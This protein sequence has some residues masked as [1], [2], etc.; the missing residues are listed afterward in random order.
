MPIY[1]GHLPVDA[2]LGKVKVVCMPTSTQT[3]RDA[4][5]RTYTFE[6]M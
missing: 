5:I 6:S 4:C 1:G 2:G 3:H